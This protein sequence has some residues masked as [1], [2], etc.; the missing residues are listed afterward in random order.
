[1]ARKERDNLKILAEQKALADKLRAN[2]RAAEILKQQ[3]SEL[4]AYT[5]DMLDSG[6]STDYE[7]KDN[8]ERPSPPEWSRKHNRLPLIAEESKID[9]SIIDK[10]FSVEPREVDLRE[11]FPKIDDKYLRRNS[12]AIW[13]TPPRYSMMP[14]Y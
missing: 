7:D 2:Q 13:N 10:F 5:F 12:S 14:K 1:M 4:V 6:D 3:R 9:A 11:I 8:R